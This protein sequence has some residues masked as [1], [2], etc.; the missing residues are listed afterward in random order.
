M[1]EDILELL[2]RKDYIPLNMPELLRALRLAHFRHGTQFRGCRARQQGSE[3]SGTLLR[4]NVHNFSFERAVED[5]GQEGAKWCV[6]GLPAADDL[7]RGAFQ[8]V[9]R[10]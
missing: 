5:G 2:Q 1:E 7:A 10:S 8:R 9:P 3:T 6:E 4:E